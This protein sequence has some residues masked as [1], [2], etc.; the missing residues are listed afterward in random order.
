MFAIFYRLAAVCLLTLLGV[1][2]GILFLLLVF[3]RGLLAVILSVPLFLLLGPGRKRLSTSL[4]SARLATYADLLMSGLLDAN[5]GMILG[6][7][8]KIAPATTRQGIV[9]LFNLPFSS[10]RQAM[11]LLLNNRLRNQTIRLDASSYSHVAY[12]APNGQGKS[13]GYA[14][15]NL[16]E[17]RSTGVVATDFKGELLRDS[18][19]T[20]M[21]SFGHEVVCYAPFGLPNGF[22]FPTATFNPLHLISPE[23]PY[24]LDYAAAI[25][26]SLIVRRPGE[27]QPFFNDAAEMLV[28]AVLAAMITQSS[29]EKCNLGNL[30]KILSLPHLME[31]LIEYMMHDAEHHSAQMQQLAGQVMSLQ[32]EARFS[33]LSTINSQLRWLDSIP[34]AQSLAMTSFDPSKLF[35]R[36][37]GLTLYIHIPVHLMHAYTGLIRTIF[38]SLINFIFE[39]GESNDRSV[40][41]YLDESQGLG[42][43]LDAVRTALIR[44]RSYGIKLAFFF[45][46]LAQVGEVFEGSEANDFMANIVPVFTGIRD[47]ETA[48]QVSSWIGKY[49]IR[50]AGTQDGLNTGMG[51]S[52]SD[53]GGIN[54][55]QNIG[56][57]SSWT[58][59]EQARDLILPEEILQLP[60]RTSII[61]VPHMPPI[62][63]SPAF[64]FQDWKRQRLAKQSRHYVLN[65][66]KRRKPTV[67]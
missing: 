41:F 25:S 28:T 15:P 20:R 32:G 63:A 11:N 7:I 17:D 31:E 51:R 38:S 59:Q 52:Y 67:R 3:E 43:N 53:R 62:F 65:T 42:S 49:T 36:Q 30:R 13:A 22:H 19:Y 50:T 5:G 58:T 61:T 6:K 44:G 64:Y 9:A 45:Q 33:V 21:Q 26:K 46:S 66:S 35:D 54:V 27:H 8:R 34:V 14:I 48:K 57:S 56:L 39:Q 55:S 60:E 12:F 10:S 4:G 37:Q 1:T 2:A 18:A 29:P 40:R 16:Q 47:M 23:S 24:Y